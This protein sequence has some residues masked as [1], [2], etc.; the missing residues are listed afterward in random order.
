MFIARAPAKKV[1]GLIALASTFA[2]VT[3]D[4]CSIIV[5]IN[6]IDAG[7]AQMEQTS[8]TTVP[9]ANPGVPAGGFVTQHIKL[10]TNGSQYD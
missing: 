2:A 7:A 10:N 4:L 3:A 8:A 9:H 5:Q 1:L 6:P